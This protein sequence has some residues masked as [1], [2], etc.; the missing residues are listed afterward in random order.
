MRIARRVIKRS[1]D[2]SE[3]KLVKD[4]ISKAQQARI[5]S[6][7]KRACCARRLMNVETVRVLSGGGDVDR[8]IGYVDRYVALTRRGF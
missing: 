7:S 1:K 4:P 2:F 8:L 6:V 5:H 3:R